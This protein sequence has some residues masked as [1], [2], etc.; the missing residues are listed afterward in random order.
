VG[1]GGASE[2]YSVKNLTGG[3]KPLP[4]TTTTADRYRRRH[5]F[6]SEVQHITL[7]IMRSADRTGKRVRADTN[8]AVD[9]AIVSF[10]VVTVEGRIACP[11]DADC[12][13]S[14]AAF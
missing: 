10:T 8:A 7:Q 13:R 2:V 6:D 1:S 14:C 3:D 5:R 11:P 4:Q 9:C 12:A